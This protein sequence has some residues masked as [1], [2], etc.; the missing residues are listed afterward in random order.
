MPNVHHG[1]IALYSECIVCGLAFH[2][3]AFLG[4]TCRAWKGCRRARNVMNIQYEL[5]YRLKVFG[6]DTNT[7][8]IDLVAC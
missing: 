2:A 6:K 8:K 1:R 7:N 3:S 4:H 5:E